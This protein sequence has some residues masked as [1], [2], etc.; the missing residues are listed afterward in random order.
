[1]YMKAYEFRT[2]ADSS[3]VLQKTRM[4]F[5]ISTELYSPLLF[6]FSF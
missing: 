3:W 5:F 6:L 4:L 1:M 2:T